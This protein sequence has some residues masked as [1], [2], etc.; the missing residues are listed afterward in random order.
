MR[1]RVAFRD[2]AETP[3]NY[4]D[5]HEYA[6]I[7][8][9][10]GIGTVLGL[11]GFLCASLPSFLFFALFLPRVSSQHDVVTFWV[12]S[13]PSFTLYLFPLFLPLFVLLFFP[14]GFLSLSWS[15]IFGF[16]VH[17]LTGLPSASFSNLPLLLFF[18]LLNIFLLKCLLLFTALRS[19]CPLLSSVSLSLF[20]LSLWSFL[21][22]F[23]FVFRSSCSYLLYIVF[24]Q[25]FFL[26]YSFLF[27]GHD[28][29]SCFFFLSLLPFP[30]FHL[31]L[32]IHIS[33][34]YP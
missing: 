29:Y 26:F 32:P 31:P 24:V 28:S 10:C 23:V 9:Y 3:L 21:L 33:L 6:A 17:F 13:A 18:F 34:P 7:S 15:C 20:F 30:P 12:T 25:F 14:C 19:P 16:I 2:I 1:V 11:S 27:T 22:S 8:V 4:A 5:V